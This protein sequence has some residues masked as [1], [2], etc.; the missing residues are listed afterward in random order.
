MTGGNVPT[1]LE[2]RDEFDKALTLMEALELALT[3]CKVEQ[4]DPLHAL[5]FVVSERLVS[6]RA[7]L[8]LHAGS[9]G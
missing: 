3:S 6:V 2:L 4:A 5:A 1:L 8:E 7:G 9:R